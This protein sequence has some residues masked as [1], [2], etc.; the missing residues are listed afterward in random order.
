MFDRVESVHVWVRERI[1]G[2]GGG[3][4][5]SGAEVKASMSVMARVR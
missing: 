5:T 1:R 4:G 2:E 3:G